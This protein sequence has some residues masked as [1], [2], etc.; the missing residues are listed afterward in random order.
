MPST[1]RRT[2]PSP[3]E[4]ALDDQLEAG[5]N[6]LVRYLLAHSDRW[7]SDE[8]PEVLDRLRASKN[9]ARP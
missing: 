8:P 6:D 5:E 3:A 4:I 9:A 2:R 7:A 1:T